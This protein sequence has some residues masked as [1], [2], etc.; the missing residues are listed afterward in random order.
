MPLAAPMKKPGFMFL[1]AVLAVLPCAAAESKDAGILPASFNGWTKDAAS[2]KTGADPALADPANADVLREYRFSGA[3]LATYTRDDRKMQ[4][5]AARFGTSSGAFGAFTFYQQPQM[6]TEQI[7]DEGASNNTRILFYRGNILVDVLL[8]RVTAMSA[9]DLRAL[10]NALPKAQGEAAG[11][12]SLPGNLPRQSLIPHSE[13]YVVGPVAMERLGAPVPPAL[14]DFSRDPELVMAK[15]RTL[16]GDAS[17]TLVSY[18]T[19]QIA[20]ERMRAM[21]AASN[22]GGPVYFKRTVAIVVMVSGNIPADEAKSL[23][24]SVNYDAEVT[25]TQPTRSNPKDNLGNLI[26]GVFLLIGFIT[27][28]ALIFGFAFGGIRILTKKMFP[29][30]VF[31]RPDDVEIIRLNL[32]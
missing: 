11:L 5:K 13:R 3:E 18:P 14:I 4:V 16:W 24:D 10:A 9:G 12:P 28:L 2:V 19:P 17:L 15:Y 29:N 20:A 30:K 1:L 8:D 25:Y 26:V 7:G 27:V 22:P 31:D 6:H 32:R 23:L 21:Q